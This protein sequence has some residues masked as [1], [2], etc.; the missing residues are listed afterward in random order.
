MI[1]QSKLIVKLKRFENVDKPKIS[2]TS[3]N[4]NKIKAPHQN[5][6]DATDIE[7]ENI[8]NQGTKVPTEPITKVPH[9]EANNVDM[10]DDA[11]NVENID[12]ASSSSQGEITRENSIEKDDIGTSSPEEINE[13]DKI[14]KGVKVDKSRSKNDLKSLRRSNMEPPDSSKMSV[15]DRMAIGMFS[16]NS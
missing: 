1:F 10:D 8:S 6:N 2:E 4:D 16:C 9:D 7:K 15:K 11:S 14:P 13:D 5:Q 3:T 12:N